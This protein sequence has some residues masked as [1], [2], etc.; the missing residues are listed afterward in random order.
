[1]AR[2]TSTRVPTS[3]LNIL[4]GLILFCISLAAQQ[5]PVCV[6]NAGNTNLRSEGLAESATDLTLS[7]SG[8]KPGVPAT[9][10]LSIFTPVNI[11]NHLSTG[12]VPD[13][14]VSVTAGGF[15]QPVPANIQLVG[16]SQLNISGIQYTPGTDTGLTIH[17]SN[18]RLNVNSAAGGQQPLLTAN[19][20]ATGLVLANTQV[21]LG[22]PAPGL[23]SSDNSA[24]IY[25]SGS[26]LPSIVN[27]ANLA[28]AGT[29]FDTIRVSEGFN[30][31]FIPKDSTSDAGTRIMIK[32][33]NLPAS[34]RLF[35]PDMIAGS[36]ALQQTSAG[37]LGVPQQT[38]MYASSANGSLLLARI[39]SPLPDGSGGS[40]FYTPPSGGTPA[41]TL[42][43]TTELSIS[44]GAAMVVYEVV[45]SNPAV[46]ESAQIPT[47]VTLTSSTAPGTYGQVSV[48]FAPLSTVG[49]ATMT[50]PVPRFAAGTPP[51]DCNVRGDCSA[52]YFPHLKM[53]TS[54]VPLS[55]PSNGSPA[56][57]FVPFQN[58]G[59]G[60]MDWTASVT[61]QTGSGWISINPTSGTGSATVNVHANPANLAPGTYNATVTIDAGL[62]AGTQSVPVT[63]TVGQSTPLVTSVG[64]SADGHVTS[65]VPG[66]FGSVYGTALAGSS[67]SVSFDGIPAVMSYTS[68]T[69][70]NLLVPA[71]LS[72]KSSTQMQVSVDG[73]QSSPFNV[74]L[75]TAA[76]A[77]FPNGVLNQ[78]SSVNGTSK[79]AVRGSI[80]QIFLT[81]LPAVSGAAVNIGNRTLQSVYSGPRLEFPACSRSM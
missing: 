28:A 39:N 38:G 81:G 26:P 73:R 6:P 34:T 75:V 12:N 74:S 64:N 55:A 9:A 24:G 67:V 49:I 76:P 14:V 27:M 16:N 68:A 29:R 61:Y 15:Q 23:L 31:A 57:G 1:M 46:Q 19:L 7:C 2:I 21:Q 17:I 58:G 50:D 4:I 10:I 62:A 36:S 37:D 63:F 54:S 70:I 45:D 59:S 8:A 22:A 32:Y 42:S 78:D 44:N 25:C 3:T 47:F 69:Q 35:V 52:S 48:S 13:I 53:N 41:I 40:P 77:V 80:L 5:L 66:S 20:V 60:T 11:T 33:S 56:V 65:L 79:P 30:N 72:G 43:S 51:A 18:L 71:A